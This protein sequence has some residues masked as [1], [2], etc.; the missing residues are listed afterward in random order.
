IPAAALLRPV[1]VLERVPAVDLAGTPV[2]T[3]SGTSDPFAADAAGLD[4]LLRNAGARLSQ[5]QLAAGHELTD[6][7]ARTVSDWLAGE[8]YAP[9]PA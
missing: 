4:D 2:V 3:V 8:R 5:R 6:D 1:R 9:Q 7:D